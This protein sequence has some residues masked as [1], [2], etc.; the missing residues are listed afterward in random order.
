MEKVNLIDILRTDKTVFTFK[1]LM[2]F[3]G[4][5]NQQLLKRRINYYISTGEFYHIRRGIYA[6]DKDYNRYELA[7]KIYTPSYISFETVLVKA[8]IIFQ[9]YSQIFMASY[10]SREIVCDKQIYIYKKIKPTVLTNHLG[11][12]IANNSIM[13]SAERA[14]L[15]T[16]YLYK[17]Y[18]FD[19]LS[20]LN[21]DKIFTIL[22][23]YENASMAQ[24]VN[25]YYAS[26]YS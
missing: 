15:D 12:E 20:T 24:K 7:T 6:K 2:L 13:A 9:Y 11:I 25:K 4:E 22:P 14:F 16:I 5:T 8:G 3:T 18:H 23:I 21:W 1:E 26:K 19:D 17:E 10:L